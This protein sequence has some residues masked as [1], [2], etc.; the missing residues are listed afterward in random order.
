M[1]QSNIFTVSPVSPL[2]QGHLGAEYWNTSGAKKEVP[3]TASLELNFNPVGH[4][5]GP[6]RGSWG[7]VP[8]TGRTESTI[9]VTW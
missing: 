6:N 8:A 3:G 5:V 2:L 7:D 9:P 4:A 1:A